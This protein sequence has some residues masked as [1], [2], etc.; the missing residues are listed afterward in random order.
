MKTTFPQRLKCVREN[1]VVPPG[2][3]S[4]L[5]L[6]P[7]LKRWAKLG[8]PSGAGFPANPF[9]T[10]PLPKNRFKLSH[11]RMPGRKREGP[12]WA[13]DLILE[14]RFGSLIEDPSVKDYST[15]ASASLRPTISA[16]RSLL[17]MPL[18]RSEEHTSELQSL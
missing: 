9:Q 5:P 13:A 16:P 18:F 4:F 12:R 1:S 7:A 15:L 3:E 8:R 2:L 17:S 10:E 11:Y 6:F 14:T